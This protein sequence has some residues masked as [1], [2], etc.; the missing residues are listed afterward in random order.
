MNRVLQFRDVLISVAW[1]YFLSWMQPQSFKYIVSR[2][3]LIRS[4]ALIISH[5]CISVYIRPILEKTWEY[6]GTEHQLSIDFKKVCDSFRREILYNILI[7]YG[8]PRKLAGLIKMCLN[9][10]CSRVCT[11]K[12]LTNLLFRMA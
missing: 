2:N 1:K 8:I 7:E 11:G 4:P 6:N 10:T 9:E 5:Q 12:N 3:R